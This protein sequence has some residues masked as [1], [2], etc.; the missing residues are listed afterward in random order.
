LCYYWEVIESLR[1][2][3]TGRKLGCWGCGI[4]EDCETPAL[5]IPL[6]LSP[7]HH[8]VKFSGNKLQNVLQVGL[9]IKSTY[10]FLYFI[11]I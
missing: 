10:A 8:E 5:S 2:G 11:F 1:G 4:E 3:A 6:P 7:S 9:T